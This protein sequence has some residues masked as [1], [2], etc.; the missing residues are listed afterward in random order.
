VVVTG[1]GAER[2]MA[3]GK[4]IVPWNEREIVEE[5]LNARKV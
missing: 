2:G 5:I 3:I 1:K 4:K